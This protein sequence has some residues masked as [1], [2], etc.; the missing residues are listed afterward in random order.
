M[1]DP[2]DM[3]KTQRINWR[4]A[5]DAMRMVEYDLHSVAIKRNRSIV[6]ALIWP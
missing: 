3:T 5:S 4:Y 6:T 2:K 1:T